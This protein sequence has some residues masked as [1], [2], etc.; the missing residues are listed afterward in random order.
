M[1]FEHSLL[2]IENMVTSAPTSVSYSFALNV[3]LVVT[4]TLTLVLPSMAFGVLASPAPSGCGATNFTVSG[5]GSGTSTASLTLTAG[6]G[7]LIA[8]QHCKVTIA[9]G[10]TTSATAQAADVSSR[11]VSASLSLP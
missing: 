4:D 1:G 2:T 7:T 10:V 9:T 3:P 6:G 11:T 5:A 8:H